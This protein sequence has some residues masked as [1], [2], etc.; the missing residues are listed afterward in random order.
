M[1]NFSAFDFAIEQETTK[2][3]AA[4][5]L[6]SIKDQLINFTNIV[7]KSLDTMEAMIP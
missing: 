1:Q 7:L 5:S 2:V 4:M 6:K 3:V